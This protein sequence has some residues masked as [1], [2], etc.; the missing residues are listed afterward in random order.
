MSFDF[1]FACPK[2][3]ATLHGKNKWIG[4]SATCNKCQQRMVIP[5]NPSAAPQ[6]TSR[7]PEV[8][9]PP[10]ATRAATTAQPTEVRRAVPPLPLEQRAPGNYRVPSSEVEPVTVN[11]I[12]VN[13]ADN[14]PSNSLGVG[15]IVLAVVGLLTLCIPVVALPLLLLGLARGI[16][17]VVVAMTRSGRGIGLP[18]AGSAICGVLLIPPTIML[19][20]VGGCVA[21][22]GTAATEPH[23]VPV[24][25]G[26][27]AAGGPMA[28]PVAADR[29]GGGA[30]S[31]TDFEAT[32]RWARGLFAEWE[33]DKQRAMNENLGNQIAT[34]KAVAR[35]NSE[36]ERRVESEF[37]KIGNRS[38]RWR[39]TVENVTSGT[40]NEPG[41]VYFKGTPRS[42]FFSSESV[43]AYFGKGYEPGYV[44]IGDGVPLPVAERLRPGDSV[45]VKG[46]LMGFDSQNR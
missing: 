10:P 3:G 20:T 33:D 18:I 31:S 23:Q 11:A 12:Q 24:G 7:P 45:V 36:A 42:G 40:G 5:P 30:F 27:T 2:C 16:G 35:A 28:A 29:V 14:R 21:A 19:L 25:G 41:R 26:P 44:S 34:Q 39:F 17:G 6:P 8:V 43:Y 13:V 32:M 22:L 4:R 15:S 38:V 46:T 1:E 9:T 37:S